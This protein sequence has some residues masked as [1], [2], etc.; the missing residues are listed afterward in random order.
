MDKNFSRKGAK[1]Q[2]K[3]ETNLCAFARELCSV[4]PK[5][6]TQ[7]LDLR[8]IKVEDLQLAHDLWTNAE[9]RRFL[10]DDR[11]ILL[12]EARALIE[13]SL[14]NFEEHGYGL[15]LAFSRDTGV[16]VGFAGFLS[17]S[18]E[19]PNLVYGVHPEF[20]GNGFA[21]EAA[22]AVLDYAFETLALSSVKADVDEPNVVSVR[23]LEKLGMTQIRRALVDGRVLLYYE[24]RR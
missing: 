7:R 19:S 4:N 15:W 3:T 8:S 18:D 14:K 11:E 20:C 12:D 10:F 16:L 13:A 1:A 6:T 9:V 2:R 17:S 21:S 5:L 22:T 24:K 23:I